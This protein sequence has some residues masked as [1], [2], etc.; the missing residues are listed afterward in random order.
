MRLIYILDTTAF[1]ATDY[2]SST[3]SGSV[4]LDDCNFH[5]SVHLDSFDVDRTLSLVSAT[6]MKYA[7]WPCYTST[8]LF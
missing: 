4:I 8:N 3:G 7:L 5:E 2:S 6:E 1:L